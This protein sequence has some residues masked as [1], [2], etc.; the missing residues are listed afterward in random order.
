MTEDI[1]INTETT[2]ELIESNSINI[3]FNTRSS[4]KV[5]D[6]QRFPFQRQVIGQ[7]GDIQ[8]FSFSNDVTE[9]K[10]V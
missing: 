2:N 9:S 5:G 7:G 1:C 4:D 3:V 8:R 6:I 10:S